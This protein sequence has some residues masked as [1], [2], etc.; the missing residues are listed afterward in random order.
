MRRERFLTLPLNPHHF[1][2]LEPKKHPN[3]RVNSAHFATRDRAAPHVFQA[4][5]PPCWCETRQFCTT[6]WDPQHAPK[7][8]HPKN[9]ERPEPEKASIEEQ[10]TTNDPQLLLTFYDENIENFAQR[11]SHTLRRSMADSHISLPL[12]PSD[13][14]ERQVMTDAEKLLVLN[15]WFAWSGGS[16][17]QAM[18]KSSSTW[19]AVIRSTDS[20]RMK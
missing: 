13:S 9:V 5:R 16:C 2:P 7:I 19:S 17:R 1:E 15:D 20:T 3:M 10:Q 11:D 18:A 6:N 14:E 4:L 12:P 8:H